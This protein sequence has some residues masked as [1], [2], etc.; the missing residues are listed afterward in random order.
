MISILGTVL[1]GQDM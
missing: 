1:T